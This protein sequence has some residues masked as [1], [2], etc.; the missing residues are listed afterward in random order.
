MLYIY[1][2]TNTYYIL[3]ILFCAFSVTAQGLSFVFTRQLQLSQD[4]L[5]LR[6]SPAKSA[7]KLLVAVG[8]LDSTVRL[9]YDDSLKFFLSLYGHKVLYTVF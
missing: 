6:Y 7:D 2:E 1:N 5:S 8:L 9:Y 4:V 3:Y